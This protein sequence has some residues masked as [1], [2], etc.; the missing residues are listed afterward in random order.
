MNARMEDKNSFNDHAALYSLMRGLAS[1]G[2]TGALI[3]RALAPACDMTLSDGIFLLELNGDA[4]LHKYFRP[5]IV[6]PDREPFT[7]DSFLY[8]ELTKP[9]RDAAV[10]ADGAVLA[11]PVTIRGGMNRALCFYRR[12]GG[13]DDRGRSLCGVIAGV[14]SC[15]LTKRDYEIENE[16][17]LTASNSA[18]KKAGEIKSEF[19]SRMSHEMRTPMN[20][21]LGMTNIARNTKDAEKKDFCL[22]KI[23]SAGKHLLSVI[24][25]ILDMSKIDS[26]KF[27]LNNF[28]FFIEKMVVDIGS[29]L[30]FQVDEKNQNFIA[31]IGPGVPPSVI[32]D[33][34]RLAQVISHLLS[35]SI[36]FTPDTG[37]IRL[38]ITLDEEREDGY[39]L[40]VS[41]I[42]SGS[43]VLPEQRDR[44]FEAFEQGDGGI[45]R[46][47]GGIGLGLYLSKYI[48]E[49]M[50]GRIWFESEPGSG[51]AFMF[52]ANV[53]KA[54]GVNA[55]RRL[56]REAAAYTGARVLVVD[57]S[58]DVR[59]YFA[60][61][62]GS[63]GVDCDVSDAAGAEKITGRRAD[64]PYDLIF[65]CLRA[66]S[67]KNNLKLAGKLKGLYNDAAIVAMISAA[68][69]DGIEARALSSGVS[70]YISK[71]ILPSMI[72]ECLR[73][74]AKAGEPG[75]AEREIIIDDKDRVF[76]A[77]A[78]AEKR[79]ED[80]HS[81]AEAFNYE[82]IIDI[83]GGLKRLANNKKLYLKLLSN[84]KGRQ[85][86]DEVINGINEGDHVKI[87]QAAHAIKG[88]ASNLGLDQ[89]AEVAKNIDEQAKM[90]VIVDNAAELIDK[91]SEDA[92]AAI[93][94][95]LAEEGAG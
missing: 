44:L 21:I 7:E 90:K 93:A 30:S 58:P 46:K 49:L 86:A 8:G 56:Y 27:K 59:D 5:G 31:E 43:G 80:D 39:T 32:G 16:R 77:E 25:D 13:W 53:K 73:K 2:E 28:E 41:V 47:H 92:A 23:H 34:H 24:N 20:A 82:G 33:G 71:P 4:P 67:N 17:I 57:D 78:A 55:P 6:E 38:H 76:P 9:D 52:T 68:G 12:D 75:Q 29:I 51:A 87:S 15:A 35:N 89:L 84:F 72:L 37:A 26:G 81:M 40:R 62:C 54:R 85:M 19:L 11:S 70:S 64:K 79:K 94:A 48:V 1:D 3:A 65:I 45:T 36:K 83:G 14:F 91:A 50:G 18:A 61:V 95:L 88:V 69:W 66:S 10:S 42:D 22:G 60:R 63:M 74:Y